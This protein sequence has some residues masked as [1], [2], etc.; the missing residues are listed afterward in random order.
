V[1]E[2]LEELR[3]GA[4][5]IKRKVPPDRADLETQCIPT[6]EALLK[7]STDRLDDLTR[8]C[9]AYLGSFASKPATFDLSALEAVWQ[10]DDPKPVVRDLVSHGLLEPS[11]GRFQMHDLLRRHA[12]SM[13]RF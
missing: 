4:D 1:K 11:G 10:I 3:S 12:S 5:I 13:Q 6:V 2:M 7:Q 8:E 9:F